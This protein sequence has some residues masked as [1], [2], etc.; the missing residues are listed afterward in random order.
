MI[1]LY[2]GAAVVNQVGFLWDFLGGYF[3]LRLLIQ[4]RYDISKVIECLAVLA[5]LIGIGMVIEE[6]TR[7][8]VFALLGGVLA[9]PEIRD[10]KV[11]SQ[12]VF[13]HALTAG[14]FAA[15]SLP[16][17]FLL[18]KSRANRV[19][20]VTGAVAVTIMVF[21]TQTSTSLLSYMAGILAVL[22]W[23]LRERMR[24]I[25]IWM[26]LA[27]VAL[28][29]VMK[30]PVWFL[31]ARVDLTGS[32][33]SYHRAELIDQFVNHFSSWW[34]IGT[35]DVATWGWDMWDAQNM[36][37]SVGEMGGLAALIFFVLVL[38]RSFSQL[39]YA[40]QA[41]RDTAEEWVPWLL[42]SALFVHVV[43]FFGVN[44][45]DQVR[46]AW[47]ALLAMISACTVTASPAKTMVEPRKVSV[48]YLAERPFHSAVR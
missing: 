28:H 13:Q 3:L 9:M 6:F 2:Q 23:P 30:A 37:V 17:F 10:G 39:G 45:F 36:F 44:Y 25:R 41:A 20:A 47:F 32:S 34:L 15:S 1:L 18:W 21:A 16:L 46:M 14:A 22:C 11:R 29:L 38:S 7:V 26:A 33:S 43:A 5:V 35:K 31:I 19:L 12:G 40:R 8:N 4:D 24:R 48:R 27:L 42:G